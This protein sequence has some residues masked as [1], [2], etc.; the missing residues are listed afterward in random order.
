LAF[1]F[2][3]IYNNTNRS[4]LAAMLFHFMVNFV[5]EL[6]A[7]SPQAEIYSIGLWTLAAI[8]IFV[9]WETKPITP[10]GSAIPR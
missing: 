9:I 6:V 1:I 8:F 3:W 7:L 2:T 10:I 4:I 5:G